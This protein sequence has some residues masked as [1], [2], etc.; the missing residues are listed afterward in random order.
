MNELVAMCGASADLRSLLKNATAEV[1]VALSSAV[2]TYHDTELTEGE[3]AE[4]TTAENEITIRETELT[5]W[6]D[7]TAFV[8]MLQASE[9]TDMLVLLQRRDSR[10]IEIPGEIAAYHTTISGLSGKKSA[11]G[12]AAWGKAVGSRGRVVA[13]NRTPVVRASVTGNVIKCMLPGKNVAFVALHTETNWSLWHQVGEQAERIATYADCQIP[14]GSLSKAKKVAQV[15]VLGYKEHEPGT[16]SAST[17][18][19]KGSG[20]PV[21]C[22]GVDGVTLLNQ[23]PDTWASAWEM[24]E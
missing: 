17:I 15:I 23:E 19:A 12:L 20:I 21:N 8:N 16:K 24:D 5:G 3:T 18:L 1:F 22:G 14:I 11:A 13:G 6:S 7:D 9:P 2:E 10:R 4:I